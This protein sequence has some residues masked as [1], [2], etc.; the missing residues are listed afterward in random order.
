[1]L[2]GYCRIDEC[3]D[4]CRGLTSHV[5]PSR[6]VTPGRYWD[7]GQHGPS[8]RG[9]P[10]PQEDMKAFT[11]F[12]CHGTGAITTQSLLRVPPVSAVPLGIPQRSSE[13]LIQGSSHGAAL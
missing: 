3:L 4:W 6:E 2:K 7:P 11:V 12:S 13:S 5:G 1:M 10:I 8:L 9:L